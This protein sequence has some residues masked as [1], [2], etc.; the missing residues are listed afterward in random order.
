MQFKEI[1]MLAGND[2][3][4]CGS[5]L[6]NW[7]DE[8]AVTHRINLPRNRISQRYGTDLLVI[9]K[10]YVRFV[11][12]V[13]GEFYHLVRAIHN[14]FDTCICSKRDR[15]NQSMR[16]YSSKAYKYRHAYT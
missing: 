12:V 5:I 4:V 14:R 6:L 10:T 11:P 15:T 7:L 13:A 8:K 16:R 2:R 9:R 1:S 3:H